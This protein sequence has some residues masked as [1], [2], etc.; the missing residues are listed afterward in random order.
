MVLIQTIHLSCPFER[1]QIVKNAITK[2]RSQRVAIAA[3]Q[4]LRRMNPERV[5]SLLLELL[6]SKIDESIKR[7]LLNVKSDL[8]KRPWRDRC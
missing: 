7:E 1:T 4:Q 8:E 3:V 5:R 2:D 6:E